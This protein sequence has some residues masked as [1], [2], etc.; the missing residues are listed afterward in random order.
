MENTSSSMSLMLSHLTVS[1]IYLMGLS[2]VLGSL[3]TVFLLLI[4]DLMKERRR[5]KPF[6][7]DEK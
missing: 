2:F 7:P 4:L 6:S 1:N 5:E 3:I